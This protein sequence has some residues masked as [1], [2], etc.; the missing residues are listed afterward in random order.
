LFAEVHQWAGRIKEAGALLRRARQLF[1]EAGGHRGA[2]HLAGLCEYELGWLAMALGD[3]VE[4]DAN[5]ASALTDE[6]GGGDTVRRAHV[7]AGAAVAA[8]A[9][10][11]A[12]R[13]A[14]SAAEAVL[15]AGTLPFPGL[16][17][18]TL[19][20][21]AEAAVLSGDVTGV[22]AADLLRTIR[23]L[24]GVR[25]IAHGLAIAAMAAE[26]RGFPEESAAALA[27]A[28]HLGE[29]TASTPALARLYEQCAERLAAA[30]GPS[31]LAT[32]EQTAT[33][34]PPHRAL[35]DAAAVLTRSQG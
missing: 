4:A 24:G 11:D 33:A 25:W 9:I 1:I 12:G 17:A 13:A 14:R 21:A 31:R 19:C 6:R 28:R 32:I 2:R 26:A 35:L 22:A 16:E 8:A 15:I 30:L 7:L 10:G 20:R 27:S 29:P 5:F 3:V 18:M 34:R 23:E